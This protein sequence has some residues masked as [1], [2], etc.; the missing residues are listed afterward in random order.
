MSK[1][2]LGQRQLPTLG[3]RNEKPKTMLAKRCHAIWGITVFI[4]I[5]VPHRKNIFHIY[6]IFSIT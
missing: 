3:L 4:N 2:T 5:C 1:L 6:I